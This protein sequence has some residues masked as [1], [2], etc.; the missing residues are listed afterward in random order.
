LSILIGLA[1]LVLAT[2]VIAYFAARTWHWVYVLVVVGIV[3]SSAGFFILSAEVLRINAVLRKSYNDTQKQLDEVNARVVALQRGTEDANLV[4]QLRSLELKMPEDATSIR[5]IN[6]LAHEIRL[7]TQIRGPMWSNVMPGGMDPQTGAV[8]IGVEAPTPSGIV[9]NTVV[10]LFEAG[11]PALPDPRTGKQYLGEFR[12]VEANAQAAVLMSTL[13][14]TE[15][16][17][18][19]L[20][21]STGPWVMYE[22][23]P[24]DRH[25]TF[26]GLSEEQ[27]RQKIPPTS[28]DEY[29]RH[30]KETKTDDEPLRKAAFNDEGKRL[31]ADAEGN[32]PEGSS[33][34]YS[35]RL[36]DYTRSFA[37]WPSGEPC[38]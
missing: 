10:Y 18:Q 6:D 20:A 28:V 36:R 12:V 19:R 15:Y 31:T 17:Q 32:F 22:A 9:A 26:A 30:G 1:I 34:V 16:Q 3:L 23:M 38:C 27:L 8:R 29:L 11:E 13:S 5:G 25:E 35:R 33:A 37:N 2:I 7:K 14:M 24:P 4:N 21:A